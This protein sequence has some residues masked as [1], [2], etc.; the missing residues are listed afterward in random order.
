MV[1]G[2][3]VAGG[4]KRVV[5]AHA[6]GVEGVDESAGVGGIGGG[7]AEGGGEELEWSFDLVAEVFSGVE[8][9]RLDEGAEDG[10]DVAVGGEVG[11]GHAVNEGGGRVVGDEALGQFVTDEVRG[12]RIGGEEGEGFDA[13]VHVRRMNLG[14]GGWRAAEV[15]ARDAC[16]PSHCLGPG[17]CFWSR[18]GR[19]RPGWDGRRSSR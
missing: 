17:S 19:G 13:F 9:G 16:E 10:F 1:G 8:L 15:V 6:H 18:S 2:D 14:L 12:V 4:W 11:G 3:V 7:G 5:E